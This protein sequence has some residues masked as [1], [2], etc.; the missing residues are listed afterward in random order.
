M[1]S[2][3]TRSQATRLAPAAHPE[4]QPF[5]IF[6]SQSATL[7]CWDRNCLVSNNRSAAQLYK[8]AAAVSVFFS[9]FFGLMGIDGKGKI[10]TFYIDWV[11]DNAAWDCEERPCVWKFNNRFIQPSTVCHEYTHAIIHELIGLPSTGE[12]GALNESIADVMAIVFKRFHGDLSWNVLDRDMSQHCDMRSHRQ[13]RVCTE[14]NDQCH[15]HDNSRIPSHVFFCAATICSNQFERV[16]H[17][18]F[19]AM[20]TMTP[21]E[22]FRSFADRTVE[23]GGVFGI[24][25]AIRAAWLD[26]GIVA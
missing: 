20:M 9:S 4:L 13:E 8:A 15:V 26:V 11:E 16:A 5:Q 22:N 2:M 18:W 25:R 21:T 23:I 7:V 6:S 1:A 17:V 3:V 12:P 14:G 19:R 24:R 10:P